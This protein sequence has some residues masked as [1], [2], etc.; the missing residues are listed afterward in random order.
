[1][2][3]ASVV[4]SPTHAREAVVRPRRPKA[5]PRW[6]RRGAWALLWTLLLVVVALWVS[7]GGIPLLRTPAGALTSTGRLC[8]L[9]ASCLM[10]VQ[11]LLMARL[12]FVERSFGQDELARRHRL[13]GFTSFSLMWAHVLLIWLGY[14]AATRQGVWSTIVDLVLDYPGILLAVAATVALCLVVVT[15][16]RAARA[17]LR[18]ES[19]HLLH[20]YAYLGVGLALPHQLWNGQEFVGSIA[21][22]VFWWGLWGAAVAAIVAFRVGMPLYRT[23]RHRVRVTEVYPEAPGVT[24]VVMSGRHLARLPA[25]AGQFFHWRF[26]GSPGSSR[27]HPYSLSEAPDGHTLRITAAHIGDGSAALATL[28]AGSRVV[29]EGPYGRLH[30]G[31]R[32]RPKV[33]LLASGIGITPIRALLEDLPQRPGDVTLVY[34]AH[35]VHHVLFADELAALA[36]ARGARILT[37][38]GPRVAARP[39]WLPQSAAHLSDAV[40][41][42]HLVPDIAQHD[43]FICG[44]PKWTALV[45]D[46]A[47]ANGTPEAHLHIERFTY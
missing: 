6:W 34:R 35:S 44:N 13:V 47:R 23:A 40:A 30:G 1:M 5:A 32:T 37:V 36:E 31:V 2:S 15:S 14:A 20:L 17:R 26:L 18:Y 46:A 3:G 45:A 42:A 19:W 24:T 21:A 12:P 8:G 11:V 22:T 10:L 28:Q 43:V 29:L 16:V 33:A 27:A 41:L 25:A 39:S 9:V 7:N 4:P 38:L